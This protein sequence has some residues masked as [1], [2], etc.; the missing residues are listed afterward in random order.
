MKSTKIEPLKGI[1]QWIYP[2]VKLILLK[3]QKQPAEVF[4][5]KKV[6]LKN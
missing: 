6:F 5:K 1:L 2:N 4:C 3:L